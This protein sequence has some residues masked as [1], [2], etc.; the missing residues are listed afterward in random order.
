MGRKINTAIAIIGALC[1]AISCSTET[2]KPE[3]NSQDF[4][5]ATDSSELFVMDESIYRT[6]NELLAEL[7]GGFDSNIIVNQVLTTTLSETGF[8]FQEQSNLKKDLSAKTIKGVGSF[9]G[10]KLDSVFIRKQLNAHQG[11]FWI[12]VKYRGISENDELL[13]RYESK[14]EFNWSAF[15][16][17]GFGCFESY[18][19]PIFNVDSSRCSLKISGVCAGSIGFSSILLFERKAKKWKYVGEMKD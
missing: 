3:V 5:A 6:V 18:G 13:S 12:P 15:Q 4:M 8:Y 14:G 10:T 19:I 9:A 11:K 17:E 16:K 2:S 7:P 1:F